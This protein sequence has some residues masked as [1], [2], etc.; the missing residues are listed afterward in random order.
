MAVDHLLTLVDFGSCCQNSQRCAREQKLNIY[1][2]WLLQV[3][4]MQV[5]ISPHSKKRTKEERPNVPYRESCFSVP[6]WDFS[7]G[8]LFIWE[9]NQ[10]I[11]VRNYSEQPQTI[12]LPVEPVTN[13]FEVQLR[14]LGEARIGWAQIQY[15]EKVS[16]ATTELIT[17]HEF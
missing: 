8:E 7:R 10:E 13:Y 16:S 9:E 3:L 14:G 1:K 5:P 17:L 15:Q 11:C 12:M 2:A 4:H 6:V